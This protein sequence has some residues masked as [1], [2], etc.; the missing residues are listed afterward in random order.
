MAIETLGAVLR[1][2]NRLFSDGAVTGLSDAELL[3]RFLA[4]R[5]GAAFEVLMARYGP[6]VLSV[7]RG[8]LRNPT[9]AEDAFQATFLVLVNKARSL[10]GRANLGGWLHLVAYRVAIQANAAAAR[11]RVQER[12]AGEMAAATSTSVPAAPDEQLRALHEEIARLPE[13]FRLAIVLC[14]LQGVP[15]D[16]AAGELQLSERTLR[17]RLSEGRERLKARL[18]RRGLAPE[19]GM[20][21]AVILRE[22]Q[23][24]VPPAWAEA[25]VRAALATVNN[26]ITIGVVSTAATTLSHEVL[27]MMMFQKLKL[28]STALLSLGLMAWGASAALISFDEDPPRKTAP[29]PTPAE[30]PAAQNVVP[31]PEKDPLDPV[32]RFPVRGRVLDPDGKPVVNAQIY[33]HHYHFDIM[34][35]ATSN[36][37]PAYQSG[38]VAAAG[39]DGRF[40]F[41]LDKSA[42]DFPYRDFPAWHGAEIAAVAPGFGPAWLTAESLLKGDEAVLRLVPD[43]VP[44]RGR[45]LDSQGRPQAGVTVSVRDIHKLDSKKDFDAILASGELAY[46]STSSQYSGPTWLGRN[47]Q[48]TTDADGRFEI[49]GVGRDQVVGLEFRSPTLEKVYLY[50]MARPARTPS[51]PRPRPTR[52]DGMRRTGQPPAPPLVGAQFERLAGPTKPITGIVRLK[53]TGK[54]LPGVHVLGTEPATWTEVSAITDDQ[55]RF[56][57]V[58]LP[59]AGSYEIRAAPRNGIDPFLGIRKTVT[60]TEGLKA[61]ETDLELPKGVI[62]IGKMIDKATGKALRAKHV[63]HTKLPTNRNEGDIATSSSGLIDPTF[64]LTVP[65][66]GNMIYANIRGPNTLYARAR[67]RPEDKG[68]GLG[69][70][71]DRETSTILL[72]AYNAYRIVDIPAN[73][74][75]FPVEL[76]LTRGLTRTGRLVGPTGKPVVG[77]QTYGLSPVWGKVTTLADDRFEV[78]GLEP[79]R[80]RLLVLAHKDLQLVGSVVLKD[81]DLKSAKPLVVRLDRA[82]SIKGRLTD[83]DGLPLAGAKLNTITFELDNN[84]LPTGP[85]GLWPDN[86]TFLT[87][88]DGRFQVNGL[89]SEVKTSIGISTAAHPRGL[90]RAVDAFRNVTTQPGEIRDLGDIRVNTNQE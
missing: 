71:G 74:E 45:V 4:E 51:K 61:I 57:L 85:G 78:T 9:D 44:I 43:D 83:E 56:R 47:G 36:T 25:T 80:P 84:N 18:G 59:K 35:S 29:A 15:Q 75:S 62:V 86:E 33:V 79:G 49:K 88:A 24:A 1:Q 54:P 14:D 68:K 5:D 89:K 81:A 32:G 8:V 82:G 21:G 2:I 28:F 39:P 17:R 30:Q 66:G 53:G 16:R 23:S 72:N 77:A 73:A 69:G 65:P 70:I 48:W 6:M 60:D 31:E 58:G 63:M 13:K 34:A 38:R 46:T 87:D 27:K 64:R 22:A 90:S 26:T 50:A 37:M 3:D 52:P 20:L 41:E 40:Q 42:S 10:R 76:E 19:G 7:C 12:E 11:R 55:G 67:L